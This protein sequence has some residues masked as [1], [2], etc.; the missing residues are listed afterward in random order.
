MHSNKIKITVD[1]IKII[2]FY[3]FTT[4]LTE[5]MIWQIYFNPTV[6]H[7]ISRRK[8]IYPTQ[9]QLYNK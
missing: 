2:V 7:K 9:I 1:I 6:N 3:D 4:N 8:N 5:W